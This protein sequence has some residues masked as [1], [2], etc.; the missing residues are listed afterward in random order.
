MDAQPEK[1]LN[2]GVTPHFEEVN[3]RKA[4][5]RGQ[6]W[7]QVF[8]RRISNAAAAH[9]AGASVDI[10]S[11]NDYKNMR[12]FLTKDRHAGY[13]VHPSGEL[14]SV[15]KHPVFG[16]HYV[17]VGTTAAAHSLLIG[18]ATHLSAYEPKLPEMYTRGGYKQTASIPWNEEYKPD[19]WPTQ[20]LGR[21][22]VA[23]MAGTHRIGSEKNT[24]I[25]RITED[26]DAAATEAKN[27][28]EINKDLPKPRGM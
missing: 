17:D 5:Y 14:V 12:L 9:P 21:P 23:I 24:I 20:V 6:S 10:H 16:N 2:W 3:P 11:V 27:L 26:Y 8:H 15:F 4:A 7:A 1:P 13:A 25:P 28:G 18:D 19:N 22:N